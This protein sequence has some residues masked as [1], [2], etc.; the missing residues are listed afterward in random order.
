[1]RLNKID[2]TRYRVG[3]TIWGWLMPQGYVVD[4]D[5]ASNRVYLVRSL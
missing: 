3:D 1:M 5:Y 2:V 4:Y